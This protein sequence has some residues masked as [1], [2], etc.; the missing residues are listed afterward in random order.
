MPIL[1]S[2]GFQT[3]GLFRFQ[4]VSEIRTFWEWVRIS[5][6][7]CI[8]VAIV[9]LWHSMPNFLTTFLVKKLSARVE[10]QQMANFHRHKFYKS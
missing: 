8:I 9:E 10:H 2:L 3:V 1:L 4:T 5:D 6:V 7:H